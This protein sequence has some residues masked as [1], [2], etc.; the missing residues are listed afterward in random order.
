MK[1]RVI[2]PFILSVTFFLI[3]CEYE[4]QPTQ[5][6]SDVETKSLGKKPEKPERITF[7]GDLSGQEDILGCCPNAGPFPEYTMTLSGPLPAGTYDGNIF[8]N[9]VGKKPNQSYMVQFW[10]TENANNYY[11]EI[12]GGAIEEDKKNKTIIATF[13]EE[14]CEIWINN[15]L[16]ATEDVSFVLTRAP[17]Q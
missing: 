2:L 3:G 11:I 6:T 15:D 13:T 8:M 4:G 1:I 9:K 10:W 5:T 12:R 16:T 7:T 17:A 14:S